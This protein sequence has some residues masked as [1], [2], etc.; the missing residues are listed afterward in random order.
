MQIVLRKPGSLVRSRLTGNFL[1]TS[2][3]LT[4]HEHLS[5]V[6]RG[7]ENSVS[8]LALLVATVVGQEDGGQNDLLMNGSQ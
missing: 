2:K 3:A 4:E 8:A 6:V 7:R 1:D 5:A